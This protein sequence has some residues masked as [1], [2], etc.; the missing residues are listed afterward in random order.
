MGSWPT[1]GDTCLNHRKWLQSQAPPVSKASMIDEISGANQKPLGQ[2]F[3]F[4][5]EARQ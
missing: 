3:L 1:G 2:Q 5:N 4:Q